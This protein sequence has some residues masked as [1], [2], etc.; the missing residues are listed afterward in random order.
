VWFEFWV[1]QVSAAFSVVTGRK[2]KQQQ[3]QQNQQNAGLFFLS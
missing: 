1:L 2:R 3:Q